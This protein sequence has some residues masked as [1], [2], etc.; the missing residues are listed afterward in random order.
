MGLKA[1]MWGS[2]I[3]WSKDLA[4]AWALHSLQ[5]GDVSLSWLSGH[6]VNQAACVIKPSI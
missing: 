4:E 2:R 5:R 1:L 6:A 3:L